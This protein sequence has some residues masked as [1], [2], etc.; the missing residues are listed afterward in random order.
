MKLIFETTYC[1]IDSEEI[2]Y[3]VYTI[4]SKT[5]L[6]SICD[7]IEVFSKSM[8]HSL[9]ECK[10]IFRISFLGGETNV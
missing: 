5:G 1:D 4:D 6:P 9:K 7:W 3:M 8:Q 10:V 2:E